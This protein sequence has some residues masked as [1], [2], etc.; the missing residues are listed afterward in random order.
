VSE[1]AVDPLNPPSGWVG[2]LGVL[3]AIGLA[4]LVFATYVLPVRA[5]AIVG[6]IALFFV[7]VAGSQF[8]FHKLTDVSRAL[9]GRRR[10]HFQVAVTLGIPTAFALYLA[11]QAD[12]VPFE[13]L[14]RNFHWGLL[15]PLGLIGWICWAAGSQL[16]HEH[17]FRGFLIAAAILGVLCWL[18]SLGMT[19]ESDYDGERS[20]TYLDPKKAK[21]AKETG[22]YVWLFVLYVTTAY[23]ALFLRLK[24]RQRKSSQNEAFL[25]LNAAL[26][27]DV[28][29]TIVSKM[30]GHIADRNARPGREADLPFPKAAIEVAFLKAMRDCTDPK[31]LDILKSTYITLDDYMLSDEECAILTKS[32]D[33]F[34]SAGQPNLTEEELIEKLTAPEMDEAQKIRK[35]LMEAMKRRCQTID[36]FPPRQA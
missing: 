33:I 30:G 22:E 15:I 27:P 28:V 5:G 24:W 3:T 1:S 8:L 20:S 11:S 19:T 16:D 36:K 6:G 25:K 18:W 2:Y 7:V 35:R 23:L 31:Y 29:Q 34:S 9:D 12:A 26:T 4:A 17:S 13:T 10:T 32:N 21:R 14:S